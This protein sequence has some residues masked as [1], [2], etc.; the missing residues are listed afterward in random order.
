MMKRKRG[1]MFLF[2]SSS[3]GPGLSP[4]PGRRDA[5]RPGQRIDIPAVTT[6]VREEE[7]IRVALPP[8]LPLTGAC[9][10]SGAL[11]HAPDEHPPR[12]LRGFA[13]RRKAADGPVEEFPL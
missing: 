3:A 13:S 12:A 8:F 11:R 5:A 6:D 7:V 10:T 1:R 4:Q 2:R 9:A